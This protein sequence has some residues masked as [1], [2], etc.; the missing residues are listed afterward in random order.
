MCVISRHSLKQLLSKC[1]KLKK[2]SLEHVKL[3]SS[4]VDEISENTKMEVLNLTMCEGLEWM[5]L[6]KLM[7]SLTK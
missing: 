2:L 1:R 5:C 4:V 3:D 7:I 6:R